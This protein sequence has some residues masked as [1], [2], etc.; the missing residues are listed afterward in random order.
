MIVFCP[1]CGSQNP[2]IPGARATCASC[3]STF[4]VPAD[5]G[6]RPPPVAAPPVTTQP[7]PASFSAPGAQVFSAGPSSNGFNATR[8][9]N[10]LAI[11]SLVA[12][13]VCCIPLVSPGIAIACGI[14]SLKQIDAS[15]GTQS[16]RGLAIAGIILGALTALFQFF[17]M[18]GSVSRGF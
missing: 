2:G 12:G 11:V 10:T 18:I 17:G 6:G 16:G 3:S 7:P 15:P 4:D 8:K 13:I 5:A 14:V 9:T 1:N